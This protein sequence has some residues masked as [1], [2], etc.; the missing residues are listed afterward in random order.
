[1]HLMSLRAYVC[2]SD[3]FCLIYD[4]VPTGSL[5]DAM[6]RVREN[7]LQLGWDARLRISVGIIK[8]LQYLQFT[9]TPTILH[10][11]LKLSNVLLDPTLNQGS[12]IVGLLRSCTLLMEGHQP[13]NVGPIS[14]SEILGVNALLMAL[15][16][17][18]G[19]CS[20]SPEN[21][22]FAGD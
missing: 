8:G 4:Y 19:D 22:G 17:G 6:K 7:E 13:L 11:N 10:Y 2:E 3:R 12:G 1:M 16:G 9:C 14:G 18:V 5:E 21:E 15:D 20:L